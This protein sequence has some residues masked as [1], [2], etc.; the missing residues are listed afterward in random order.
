MFGE[1]L[2][3]LRKSCGMNQ[4]ELGRRL[5]VTKQAVSNWENNNILP[6]VDLLIRIA[7]LFSVS[8]DYLLEIDKSHY[9]E[10]EGLSVEEIAHVQQIISDIRKYKQ[11]N[12]C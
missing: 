8:T 12:V 1:V 5:G 4:V 2:Q 11:K 3:K 10:I 6:S 7:G 9:I